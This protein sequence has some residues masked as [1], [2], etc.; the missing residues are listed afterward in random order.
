MDKE[1]LARN[2]KKFRL[3]AGLTQAQAG[4][5]LGV[6]RTTI[7]KWENGTTPLVSERLDE[8]AAAFGISVDKLCQGYDLDDIRKELLEDSDNSIMEEN[9]LLK[10]RLKALEAENEDLK[11]RVESLSDLSRYQK[12]E[13]RRLSSLHPDE[14]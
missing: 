2:L 6:D 10:K 7:I 12:A 13:L 1:S 8:I 3:E 11:E 14:P 9:A 5:K 4:E